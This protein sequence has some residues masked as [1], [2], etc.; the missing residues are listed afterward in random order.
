MPCYLLVRA[1]LVS[2]IRTGARRVALLSVRGQERCLELCAA[3]VGPCVGLRYRCCI[4]SRWRRRRVWAAADRKHTFT[5]T[6]ERN[7]DGS[8][9]PFFVAQ[10]RWLDGSHRRR[11]GWNFKTFEAAVRLCSKF[12]LAPASLPLGCRLPFPLFGHGRRVPFRWRE[13]NETVDSTRAR[14]GM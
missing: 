10:V 14:R 5:I 3:Y 6:H 4:S 13:T 7:V 2:D 12:L 11:I 9:D 1:T 8:P